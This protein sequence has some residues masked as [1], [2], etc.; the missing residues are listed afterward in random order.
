MNEPE[1]RE[2]NPQAFSAL[3]AELRAWAG[4]IMDVDSHEYTPVN[5]WA[6]QFGSVAQEFADAFANSKMPINRRVE[7]DETAISEKS[8]WTT[9]FARAPGAFDFR[10][11]LDVMDFIGIHR[12]MIF[13]G[14]IGLYAVSFYYRADQFPDMFRQI[15]G[16]R[17]GYARQLIDAYN[18]FCIRTARTS[19]RL[20]PVGIALADDIDA[21]Y[22]GAKRLIDGGVRAIWVP[23]ASLPGGVSPASPALD[24]FYSLL[25]AAN[26]PILAHVGADFEFLQTS[27]WRDAPAFQGWKAG[28]E[29]QM[30]PWTLSVLHLPVQNFLATMVLGGVFERHP[31]LRFGACEVLG[32]WVGPL[33]QLLDFWH[34]HSRKFTL[35]NMEGSLPIRLKPSEYVRR[36]VRVSLFDI[37]P[38]DVY[39]DQFGMPE[40]YCYASDY[41]HPEGGIDPMG[42]I[43]GRLKRFGPQVMKKVFIDNGRWLLPD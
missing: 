21:L 16:D 1:I 2:T 25:A 28:E 32:Q 17:K 10:R 26:A 39:I 42:D 4:Q 6:E 36:N 15:R 38:V 35:G 18:E 8:V 30:D 9:K 12:Q 33:A 3:P 27:R 7:R 20:R 40:V 14:S 31:T 29:F 37:E 5:F 24:R 34:A 19:D 11:R 13:P 22:L 43:S 41:P 23:S